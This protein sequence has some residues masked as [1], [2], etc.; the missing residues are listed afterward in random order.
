MAMVD[1]GNRQTSSSSRLAWSES[2]RLPS[3]VL[4][5]SN[6][7][8]ELSHW[9]HDDDSITNTVVF[10]NNNNNNNNNNIPAD[11]CSNTSLQCYLASRELY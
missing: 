5:S 9:L 4:H 2:W 3:A 11:I 8:G 7:P 10:I 1:A 6:E